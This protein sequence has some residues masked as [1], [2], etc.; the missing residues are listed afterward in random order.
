MS[1]GYRQAF[2]RVG[3]CTEDLE[4]DRF[5][6]IRHIQRMLDQGR[7]D[8]DLRWVGGASWGRP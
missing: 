4:G 6:R 1:I 2:E 3:L 8:A 5:L 7:L